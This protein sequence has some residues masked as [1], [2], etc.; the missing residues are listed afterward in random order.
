MKF[1]Q[2]YN[3]NV[4][5]L[6]LQIMLAKSE[7]TSFVKATAQSLGFDYCGIAKAEK[8]DEESKRLE[9]WLNKGFN[10]KMSYMENYFDLRTDPSKLVPGAKSVITLLLNYFPSQQ[11]DH[12]VP[13]ISKYAY[14]ND[15]HEVIKKKLKVFLQTL[16]EN[17]GEING[18][19]F[20]DSAPVLERSWA[21]KSG[22]GWVGK[23]GNLITKN[24]GS[25]FFI[26]TLITD[27]EL[28]PDNPFIKDYCGSCTRC[29]DN[30]PT[31]A[32]LPDKVIDGSKCI[33]YYTI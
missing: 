8:L 7:Y 29:I 18:R 15:Y 3:F 4:A 13:Q 22:L 33:S 21:V 2:F 12:D 26:A 5:K 27:L 17:I 32:I 10:G 9:S 11:Q 30:C 24:N 25:F 16:K 28:E 19:G 6:F 1:F 23:N 31:E 20:T 14:G